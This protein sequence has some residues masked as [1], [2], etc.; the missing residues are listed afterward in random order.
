MK[1]KKA[2]I[3]RCRNKAG[4][5]SKADI[6][7]FPP[8][9]QAK[10]RAQL[11]EIERQEKRAATPAAQ[12]KAE[13]KKRGFFSRLGKR[14]NVLRKSKKFKVTARDTERC[15]TKTIKVRAISAENAISHAKAKLGMRYDR[16]KVA[17]GRKA[18]K[19][20]KKNGTI[21]KAKK[22][23][24]IKNG[25]ATK[26]RQLREKFTG[27]SSKRSVQMF[28]PDGTPRNLAKLGRLVAIKTKRRRIVPSRR[29]PAEV[30]WLCAD[31]KGRLHLCT[32]GA[33]LVEGPPQNFGE[34]V[35]I[36]YQTPKPHLGHHRTTRFYHEMGEEGGQ[37]PELVSDGKGGLKFKGGDYRITS[38]GI[39]D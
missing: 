28:A 33:R 11:D 21:V 3:R 20:R 18:R 22:V 26:T 12:K 9:V 38:D 35:E 30:V 25:A 17:N 36:E 23:T 5:I 10:I 19:P 39:V 4:S 24:I 1:S 27:M 7:K 6:D 34:V 2:T 37:R 13:Q 14:L 16:L 29:N 15:P 31:E 32:T 8:A